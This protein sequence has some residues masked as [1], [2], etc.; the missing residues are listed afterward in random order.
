MDELD[1]IVQEFV[2]ESL[3][4]VEQIDSL[5]LRL[6]RSPEDAE[7]LGALFRTVHSIKG[8]SGFLGFQRLEAVAHRGESVLARLRDGELRI[9]GAL[10][11]LLLRLADA[12]R[13]MLAAITQHG[14]DGERDF[15]PLQRA[16]SAQLASETSNPSQQPKHDAASTLGAA[17][18]EPD[19]TDDGDPR[20]DATSGPGPVRDNRVR[21]DVALLDDLLNLVGELVL[22]RNRILQARGLE[23]DADLGSAAQRLNRI[24]GELQEG[25]MKT[26]MQPIERAWSRF[27]RIVRDLA[28]SCE[29]DVQIH[30]EGAETELDRT[31]IE[32]IRDPMT[33]IVRN[34]ID[35]GIETPSERRAA[36]KNPVGTLRLRAYHES[37][38][39]YVV[40]SDDGRGLDPERISAR[41]VARGLIDAE[42]AGQM[43]AEQLTQLI[44]T[45]GF[46]TAEQVTRVSGRG[47]GLDVVTTN[48]ERIGGAVQIESEPG[49]GCT[50]RLK[51]PLTLAI[52]PALIIGSA[53]AR[54]AVPQAS[55]I[56]LVQLDPDP[57]RCA[58]DY[59]FD[60]PMYRLRDQILPLVDLAGVLGS[61]PSLRRDEE[62][63]QDLSVVVLHADGHRFGLVVDHIHDTEEIVVKPLAEQL[64]GIAAF[65]GATILG[66]GRV[67]LI[68]NVQGLAHLADVSA[69]VRR[70][71]AERLAVQRS[72]AMAPTEPTDESLLVVAVDATLRA[73][74]PLATIARLE[75]LRDPTL[76]WAAGRP[77]VRYHDRVLPLLWLS[78]LLEGRPPTEAGRRS[79]DGSL[80]P[81]TLTVLIMREGDVELAIA[82]DEILDIVQARPP[83]EPRTD[84]IGVKGAFVLDGFI[85]ERIALPELVRHAAPH[86]FPPQLAPA[87]ATP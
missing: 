62:R 3:E 84:R 50:V 68:L 80:P 67:A 16:L 13:E 12:L 7:A 18:T 83:L 17:P 69:G 28:V 49:L 46:S 38:H 21:V 23:H 44:L 76:A 11:T 57:A 6:E 81:A 1:E 19:Q 65:T 64:K 15:G 77:V 56:E 85:T 40:I 72:E 24:T 78:D 8:T 27:P 73:A 42:L 52:V 58:I 79:D 4:G 22:T 25:L 14:H 71:R 54:Y 37:G 33:H 75:E 2:I 5:L 41:A 48:V 20:A 74:L 26:R 82:V 70:T 39:V 29:K 34:A 30:V 53:G 10:T 61:E 55:L 9:D 32:A 36:G 43:S 60:S 63:G 87:G 59:I 35:H 31:L 66:D 51:I 86:L 45:P 47:V